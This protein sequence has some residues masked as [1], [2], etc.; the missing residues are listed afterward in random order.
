MEHVKKMALV[1]PRLLEGVLPSSQPPTNIVGYIMRRLDEDMKPSS[2]ARTEDGDAVQPDLAAMQ[3]HG[4]ETRTPAGTSGRDEQ[5]RRKGSG[6]IDGYSMNGGSRRRYRGRNRGKRSEK[7]EKES[8]AV[9]GKA[10]S[11]PRDRVEP[12][13]GV[14]TRRRRNDREQHGGSAER[15]SRFI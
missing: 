5:W 2:I 8:A 3:R 10:E 6:R 9:S 7:H 11:Q 15:C 4:R 13:R 14:L 1:D 12:S